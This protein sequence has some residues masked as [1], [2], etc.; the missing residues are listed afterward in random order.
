MIADLAV[1][2]GRFA[3]GENPIGRARRE[4][5]HHYVDCQPDNIVRGR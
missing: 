3:A 4:S 5:L 2:R 1:S